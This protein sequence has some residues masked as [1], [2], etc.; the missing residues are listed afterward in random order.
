MKVTFKTITQEMFQLSVNEDQTILE[1]KNA[2][3]K[4]R[5]KER[6]PVERQK[7]IYAGKIL[8]DSDTFDSLDYDAK[9][10]I[11][12]MI[13]AE[14]KVTKEEEDI[15]DSKAKETAPTKKLANLSLSSS[16]AAA[17]TLPP[18]TGATPSVSTASSKSSSSASTSK[19]SRSSSV[20]SAKSSTSKTAAPD[21]SR[22]SAPLTPEN[23]EKLNNLI[24]MGYP[25]AE[26]LAALRAAFFN[27][28]RAVEYLINGIPD[29]VHTN[30]PQSG[31]AI[32]DEEEN[33]GLGF[34]ENNAAFGQIRAMVQEN[35]SIL[36]EVMEKIA[37]LNPPLMHVISQ[38][39]DEFL[40]LLNAETSRANASQSNP[41]AGG[42]NNGGRREH[43]VE[44]TEEERDAI[45]RIKAMGFP[46]QL[47][48]EAYLACD[49]NEELA[50]NYIISRMTER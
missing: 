25:E 34:L 13:S 16:G 29:T 18:N 15:S 8:D 47:A 26:A 49:K 48:I 35:P 7:L 39:Q 9:K 5:G 6:C 19:A 21:S 11:V 3:A 14:K 37:A 33:I 38:N 45:E 24:G 44:V 17:S 23:Q 4:N 42:R 2:I 22:N 12:L 10:V 50:V 36:T 28:P 27:Q 31:N 46:E 41:Q 30:T 43:I 20:S 40:R 32:E 1:V